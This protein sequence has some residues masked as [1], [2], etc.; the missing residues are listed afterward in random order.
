MDS[1]WF[2]EDRELPKNE[3]KEAVKETEKV[4]R[5]STI[6]RRRLERILQDEYDTTLRLEE[7]FDDPN[8][9]RK[10]VAAISRRKT[11]RDLMK[12]IKF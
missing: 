4:L 11:L 3:Q 8:W 5:N 2:K 9:E 1:R 10:H 12:L 7:D 6:F